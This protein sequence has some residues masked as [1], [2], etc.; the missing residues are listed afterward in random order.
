M[1]NPKIAI[2]LLNWNGKEDTIE[3]LESLKQIT[4][5]N[6]EILLVDN[7]STDRSVEYFRKQYPEIELIENEINLGYAEGNNVGIRVAIEKGADYVLLLNNDTVVDPE[8]LSELV[9]VGDSDRKIGFAG[10][11]I[12]YY[13][14]NG[15]KDV[16]NFAGGKLDMWRGISQHLGLNEIDIGQYNEIKEVDYIEG[17]CL[18][19]RKE[20]LTK[21]GLLDRSFFSYWEDNDWCRR[22]YAAGFKS[23]YVPA[24]R[25][26]H[27]TSASNIGTAKLYYLTRNRMWFM[28]KN[29]TQTQYI[30][31]LINFFGY[32]FW[33]ICGVLMLYYRD[34]KKMVSFFNGVIDGL[35]AR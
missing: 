22:G 23:V 29:A 3:C 10:P 35:K 32:E 17:S 28:K 21:I 26:W 11:K 19:M 18:L 13:N 9:K 1:N 14:Y 15:R 24:A 33:Y 20:M 7:G 31:F 5:T 2:I 12:Y 27:K 8:F 34:L 4:Y 30:V 25:I 16:I 6:Y